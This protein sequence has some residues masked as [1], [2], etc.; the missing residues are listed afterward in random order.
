M[1]KVSVVRFGRQKKANI[2][3]CVT[4]N[5]EIVENVVDVTILGAVFFLSFLG[6]HSYMAGQ[7]AYP[8]SHVNVFN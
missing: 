7:D 3:V 6:Y 8:P 4:S 1:L 5:G 2:P